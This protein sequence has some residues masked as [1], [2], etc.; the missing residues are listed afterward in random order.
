MEASTW[1]KPDLVQLLPEWVTGIGFGYLTFRFLD[2]RAIAI[3]MAVITLIF[4]DL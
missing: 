1:S 2:H 4:A 3:V